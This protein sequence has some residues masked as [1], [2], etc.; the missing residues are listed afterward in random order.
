MFKDEAGGKVIDEFVGL[1]VELYSYKMFEGEKCKG[2][3][4]SV[5]K[6]SI[7][8][9]D[10]KECLFTGKEQLRRINVIRS[11]KHE[12]YTE[13]VNKIALSPSDDKRHILDDGAHTLALGHYRI[14]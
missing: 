2:V 14:L 8:H 7:A 4:K 5:V 10:Y 3:K 6:R 11:H 13:E 9:E 1:R 12:I